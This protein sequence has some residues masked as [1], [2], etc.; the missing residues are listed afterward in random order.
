MEQERLRAKFEE[1]ISEQKEKN[2]EEKKKQRN[3]I[4]GNIMVLGTA[5]YGLANHSMDASWDLMMF[6][7]LFG[8]TV[9]ANIL[10][11]SNRIFKL[12]R[13]YY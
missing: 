3:L 8:G 11:I 4:F 10:I 7:G 5:V 2:A 13:Q 9:A 12:R 6:M 1:M